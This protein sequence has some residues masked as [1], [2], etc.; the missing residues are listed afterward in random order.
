M[1]KYI[2]PFNSNE[3]IKERNNPNCVYEFIL[4]KTVMKNK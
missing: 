4:Q 1:I 3:I 2:I